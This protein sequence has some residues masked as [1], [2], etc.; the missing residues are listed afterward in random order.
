M[1]KVILDTQVLV[2]LLD[3]LGLPGQDDWNGIQKQIFESHERLRKDNQGLRD[4][5]RELLEKT[6]R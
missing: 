3:I 2:N 4:I 1:K 5:Y 6:K